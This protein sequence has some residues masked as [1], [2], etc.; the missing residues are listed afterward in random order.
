MMIS[1]V[2]RV[3]APVYASV[4]APRTIAIGYRRFY[5]DKKLDA[6]KKAP[7]TKVKEKEPLWDRVKHEV[8]HYVNGTKLLGYELKISTKLLAKS[9]QGYELTRRERNQLK[10]TVGDIFRLVP[11][12]AFV[13]IP[14]AEL[15]LP[16]ALKLFPNLLP[17]TYES[18]SDKQSKR[19]K[20]IEIR[21]NTSEFLHKT[22]EESQFISYKNIENEEK[23]KTFLNFF[24]KLYALKESNKSTGPIIF[25]HQEIVTIAKMFKNDTVLD[26]LSRPQLAAM[27]KFMSIRPFGND[28]MLRYQ[29]RY[30]LK[31]IMEDDKTIDYEGVKSLT[32]EELYQACVSRGMKAYGV[33]KED[34]IDNLKVWLDLR[35]R[36]K[37]PS[38][39][40][41]LSSTFTFGGPQQSRSED[42]S[43]SLH[44]TATEPEVSEDGK[45]LIFEG[46]KSNYEKLL[47]LYYDGILQV[48][49]SIPDPVYNVAKLD[50]NEVV[51][52]VETISEVESVAEEGPSKQEESIAKELREIAKE[53][54]EE[55]TL[56]NSAKETRE[57]EVDM[58][59]KASEEAGLAEGSSKK[60]DNEFKLN[61]L[62][63]QEEL[64]KKEQEEAEARATRESVSDDIT[65]DEEEEVSQPPVP[66]DQAAKTSITKKN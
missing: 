11:F 2:L 3:R 24:Q 14:F 10:R 64:I 13:I 62:K 25:T 12:S 1:T 47:D 56:S 46:E 55:P 33:S 19:K 31:S 66:L 32:P 42:S 50:L 51:K 45:C 4:C 35:L 30:K 21:Q 40:M 16:V 58:E 57:V 54:A 34:Q 15:L 53:V 18:I 37:I 8:K 9:M 23:K 29:I 36:K 27:C 61:V 6:V 60:D 17:S 22:L 49:S 44:L 63:E 38:V 41:V 52:P 59:N 5:S 39:L 43:C 7:E 26:N 28:P 65:L 20:L 48:L